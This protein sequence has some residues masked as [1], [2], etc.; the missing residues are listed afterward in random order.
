MEFIL[1]IGL[2][3]GIIAFYFGLKDQNKQ[4][5]QADKEKDHVL[6]KINT[7]EYDKKF[8]SNDQT[9]AILFDDSK[10]E[11]H[12]LDKT[13]YKKISYKE[14][15]QVEVV[16]DKDSITKTSRK[17]QVGG[18]VLGGLLLGSTGAIIGGL[19]SQKRHTETL[20]E[21]G[22]RVVVNDTTSPIHEF[23]FYNF[24]KP[25]KKETNQYKMVY[26]DVYEWFKLFE[27]LI[28]QADKD[29]VESRAN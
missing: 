13:N 1:F 15:L 11:L 14:L 27:V 2:T 16:E 26:K 3:I 18:A 21:I 20:K 7:F 17:G 22:L 29:D 24:V 5:I 10:K 6:N 9:K 4:K 25:I 23:T 8:L 12:F 19:S 28:H